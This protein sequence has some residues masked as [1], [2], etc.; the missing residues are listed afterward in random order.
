MK[1]ITK[2]S[3]IDVVATIVS[4][5]L[6]L[7]GID[8]VL[9]GGAVVSIYTKNEYE[10]FDLDFVIPGL[11]KK[12]DTAMSEIGFKK[13]ATRHWVH[14]ENPY[15]VEFPGSTISIGNSTD[16]DVSELKTSAGKLRLLSPTSSVMDRLA[17]YY[18]WNDRQG[19]DQAVM[20]AKKH[21]I[22]IEK[23]KMWSKNEGHEKKF[24][25]FLEQWRIQK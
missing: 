21:P 19:L 14:P 10:S 9:V 2:S 20:I 16:V 6:K 23:I 13:S 25:E 15:Y 22:K 17:A 12:V 3:T 7:H 1:K 5:T 4:E 8:V 11:A 18:H 24:S